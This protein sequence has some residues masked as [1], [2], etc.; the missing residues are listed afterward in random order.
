MSEGLGRGAVVRV[1][2]EER[3]GVGGRPRFGLRGGRGRRV[4]RD[5]RLRV[6]SWNI[7][8]LQGKSIELVKILRKRRI[9]IMCVHETKRVGSKARN[10]DGYKLWYSGSERRRN[11]VLHLSR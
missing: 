4:D 3:A 11:G 10:V 5:G 2:E 6:G 7:G 9:N 1:E 8:T